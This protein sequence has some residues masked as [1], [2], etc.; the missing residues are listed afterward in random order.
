LLLPPTCFRAP[1]YFHAYVT[2]LRFALYHAY[3]QSIPEPLAR[4][5]KFG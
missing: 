4:I 1:D 5:M 2:E 3:R